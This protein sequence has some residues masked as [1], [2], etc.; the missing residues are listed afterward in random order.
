[1]LVKLLNKIGRTSNY[2]PGFA[3]IVKLEAGC[4]SA[5]RRE[6]INKTIHNLLAWTHSL[7]EAHVSSG[8]QPSLSMSVSKLIMARLP[9][10]VWANN[11]SETRGMDLVGMP[12]FCFF[13]FPRLA[14]A[15]VSR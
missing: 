3:Q 6:R 7:Q 4:L 11:I 12:F 1:M 14:A 2:A 9:C 5:L 10:K 8:L 15:A 13:C